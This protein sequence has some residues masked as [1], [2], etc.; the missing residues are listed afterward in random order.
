V[1]LYE[2]LTG[3]T[4][5]ERERL[6]QVGLLEALRLIREE[7][8]RRPSTRLSTVEDLPGIAASRGVEPRKL[9]YLVRGELDWIVMKALEKNRNRRYETANG[10]ARDIERYLHDEPVLACPP[11][12]GYQVRKL[13][14]RNRRALLS[15]ALLGVML[16]TVAGAVGGSLAWNRWQRAGRQ[17]KVN[18][19]ASAAMQEAGRHTDRALTLIDKPSQWE[20]ALAAASSEL[21]RVQALAD[22]EE[23]LLDPALRERAEALAARLQV[24]QKDRRLVLAVERIRLEDRQPN[25][26]ESRFVDTE[27]APPRYRQAFEAAGMGVTIPPQEVAALLRRKPAAIRAALLAALNDWLV[28]AYVVTTAGPQP[29]EWRKARR[30]EVRWLTTVLARADGDGWRKQVRAALQ[31]GGRPTLE[32][33]AERPQAMQHSPATLEMLALALRLRGSEKSAIHLLER[34][35]ERYPSDFWINHT[36]AFLLMKSKRPRAREA[37][38]FYRVALALRPDNAGVYLNMGNALRA[39]GDLPGAISAYQKAVALA[40]DYASAYSN[41]GIALKDHNDLPAAIAAH[42]K[43]IALAPQE[44]LFHTNLGVAL[45]AAGDLA[46]AITAHRQAMALKRN[47]AVPWNNLGMV[48][49][50]R[51]DPVAAMAAYQKAIAINPRYADAYTHLGGAMSARG[52]LPGAIAAQQKAVAIAPDLAT[53]HFNLGLTLYTARDY[54]GA[55]AAYRKAIDLEPTY[56]RGHFNLGMALE[57]NKDLPAAVAAFQQAIAVDPRYAEAHA[58]LGSAFRRRGDLPGAIAAYQRAI[59]VKPMWAEGHNYLGVALSDKGDLSGATRAY[60]KAIA[61]DPKLAKA[62]GNLGLALCRQDRLDEAEAACREALRLEPGSVA[63]HNNLGLVLKARGDLPGAI[64]AF[65]KALQNQPGSVEALLNLASTLSQKGAWTE[66]NAPLDK[67]RRLHPDNP[68]PWFYQAMN[69]LGAAKGPDYRRVCEGMLNRFDTTRTP[70]TA[71]LLLYACVATPDAVAEPAILIPLAKIAA[72]KPVGFAHTPGAALYRAGKYEAA[73]RYF[74]AREKAVPLRAWDYLFL[75]M[76]HQRLGHLEEAR[77]S[78]DRGERWIAAAKRQETHGKRSR[79]AA[80][81]ERVAV[82]RL[83]REAETLLGEAS[84][85]NP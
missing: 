69:L 81:F 79:W 40:P 67:A 52:D 6:K 11:S 60:R 41:L 16:L 73:V 49:M 23:D 47:F 17:A 83:H 55:I 20:A 85:P 12:V 54:P 45:Q 25:V 18:D 35:Q 21:R 4:P 27:E 32:A 76:A 70:I 75:A 19:E 84:P 42:R 64:A 37:I 31:Q 59:A 58:A 61:C 29:R 46:G 38:T 15:L 50:D 3:T 65:Q 56:A 7:E 48:L 44:A 5:L 74:D 34:A 72:I 33:L 39:A 80:W 53:A 51:K 1:L 26:K 14:W 13:V 30:Q 66:A 43:A 68:H 36:L 10:L 57:D 71:N 77:R 82:E 8:T 24:D 9:S 78:L 2:L 62:H 28:T 63:A 22:S